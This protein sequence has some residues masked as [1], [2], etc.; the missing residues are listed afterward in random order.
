MKSL[1]FTTHTRFVFLMRIVC[2]SSIS[3]LCALPS[4]GQDD[5]GVRE[6]Q[7]KSSFLYRFIQFSQWPSSWD[8]EDSITLCIAGDESFPII[9][10]TLIGKTISG[11]PILVRQTQD[12]NKVEECHVL[13]VSSSWNEGVSNMQKSVGNKP[14]LTIGESDNFTRYGG[15]IRFYKVKNNIRFEI[16]MEAAATVGITFSSKLLKLAKIV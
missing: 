14:I 15:L 3:I 11:K 7:I 1:S 12:L 16:N 4:L 5:I 10:D 2:I 9:S 13:F 8:T 6:Y